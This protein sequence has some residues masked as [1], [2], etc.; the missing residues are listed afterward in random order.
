MYVVG[1]SLY[2]TIC[3]L[4][5][6][7]LLFPSAHRDDGTQRMKQLGDTS[8]YFC[9]HWAFCNR[10]ATLILSKPDFFFLFF[11]RIGL[12]CDLGKP[13]FP[14]ALGLSEQNACSSILQAFLVWRDA[15]ELME[16]TLGGP[17]ALTPNLWMLTAEHA[18]VMSPSS[19]QPCLLHLWWQIAT[20][21]YWQ[22][23]R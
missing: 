1:H 21:G 11:Q 15:M 7:G 12:K 18:R 19:V 22:S 6:R 3:W 23:G 5:F 13:L 8:F 17:V 9:S 2:T 20:K 16:I 10:I 14:H 4:L